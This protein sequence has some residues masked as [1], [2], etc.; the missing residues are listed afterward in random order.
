MKPIKYYWTWQLKSQ[1]QEIWQ[2]IADTHRLNQAV[3]TPVMDV[4]EVP[5]ETGGSDLMA[6]GS[7][8][9]ITVSWDEYPF[10]W[11]QNRWYKA[12]R[13]FK[14]G[15]LGHTSVYINLTPRHEGTWCQ[16]EIEIQPANII[17]YPATI[18]QVGWQWRQAYDRVVKQIDA[19]IQ[20]THVRPFN[21]KI[22]RLSG[23]AK[24]RLER[25]VA[26]LIKLGHTPNMIDYLTTLLTT[27]ADTNLT[28]IRPYA[29]ANQ[30]NT[31]RRETLELCLS[32]AKI[33]L[34]N[35]NWDL[36]C[37]LCRGDKFTANTL[38]Q[39]PKGVHCPTCNFDFTAN[40]S[41]NIELTFKPHPQIRPI[42]DRIYCTGGPM[43]TPHILIHQ[44]L[45]PGEE[46]TVTINLEPG[47][48][49]LRT[50]RPEVINWLTVKPDETAGNQLHIISNG[51]EL[52][53]DK[54][55]LS[56]GEITIT[57]TNETRI[58]QRFYLEY[59]EW[60]TNAV[61]AAEV[62]TLQHFRDLFSDAVLHP[63]EEIGIQG[64]S[65]LFSDLVGSTAMYNRIGD[66]PSYALVREQ[67]SFL[68]RIVRRFDGGIVK[69]IGDAIMG[70]FVNPVRALSASLAIQAQIND[71]N[72][73]YPETPIAIKL[74]LHHGPCIAVTLNGRLDYF[75][76]TV[77]MAARLEGQSRGGDIVISEAIYKDPGVKA[78]LS[79][80]SVE[81]NR[82]ETHIKGFEESFVLYRLSLVVNKENNE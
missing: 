72:K 50:Q 46:R 60:Y 47:R 13:N 49:R 42:Y 36:M 21:L 56:S 34:L 11:V 5:L 55:H 33:G 64:M 39:I 59:G 77:N 4:T 67:F 7:K 74:G 9:G 8:Y 81:I 28:R 69:T 15:P 6:K 10:D 29:L 80:K 65:I 78:L 16:V 41:R 18:F 51:D 66:A 12:T 62:T 14:S 79:S 44:K 52:T 82:F 73:Q 40:F 71:F 19:S 1:P 2:Y 61:T 53:L 20:N 32:A 70:A 58:N 48:Y 35:M 57:M 76:T 68:Q 27:E 3:G 22:T 45:S 31:L 54:P 30:W 24:A 75:G 43:L 63:G 38:D 23:A 37:P 25:L 17:G 26:E